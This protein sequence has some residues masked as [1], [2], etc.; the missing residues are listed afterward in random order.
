MV[1]DDE[2]CSVGTAN[3]DTRSFELNFEV[4]AII[5]SE[6]IAKQQK[7]Q[8][9]ADILKSTELTLTDYKNRSTIVKIKESLSRLFSGVL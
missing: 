2:V 8:F 1:I 5:Y 9:E 6:E 3:M 7:N 4:N